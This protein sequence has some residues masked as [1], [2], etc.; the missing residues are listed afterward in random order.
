MIV[1]MITLA[2]LNCHPRLEAIPG[3]GDTNAVFIQSNS[4]NSQLWGAG[5]P[6]KTQSS[7]TQHK[8]H[9][10]TVIVNKAILFG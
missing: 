2:P 4:G 8:C 9:E 10:I 5:D 1:T 7:P 3:D 6:L